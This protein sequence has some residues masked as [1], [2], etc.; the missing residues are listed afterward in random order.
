MEIRRDM[1]LPVSLER[2][3]QELAVGFASPLVVE[4]GNIILAKIVCSGRVNGN[5][6]WVEY[7]EYG[8]STTIINLK[9]HLEEAPGGVR[10]QMTVLDQF[11]GILFYI[12]IIVWALFWTL[13]NARSGLTAESLISYF[14]VLLFGSGITLLIGW[15][16]RTLSS[17]FLRMR[18]NKIES[19]L[20]QIIT[21]SVKTGTLR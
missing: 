19:V 18:I 16:L 20:V 13:R 14:I 1:V 4:G 9:G 11:S 2:A 6:L 5:D 7:T 10:L 21:G 17:G 3:R 12:P 15:L 8:R